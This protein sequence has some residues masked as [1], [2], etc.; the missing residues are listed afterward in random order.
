MEFMKTSRMSPTL[1]GRNH[2]MISSTAPIIVTKKAVYIIPCR[3]MTLTAREIN[4]PRK[5]YSTKCIRSTQT[6]KFSDKN[7]NSRRG[8][9]TRKNCRDL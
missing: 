1:F 8:D 6:S 2:L 7:V 3:F 4:K 5:A 9:I